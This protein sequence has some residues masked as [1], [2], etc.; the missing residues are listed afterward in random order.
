MQKNANDLSIKNSSHSFSRT[1]ASIICQFSIGTGSRHRFGTRRFCTMGTLRSGRTSFSPTA[2]SLHDNEAPGLQK[3]KFPTMITGTFKVRPGGP[4]LYTCRSASALPAPV[5]ALWPLGQ[6]L[7]SGQLA[8]SS[9]SDFPGNV[10]AVQ[11]SI[12][13]V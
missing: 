7:A 13:F 6:A 10:D 9:L 8:A 2:D 1:A 12:R 3:V 5:L 4:G 11:P